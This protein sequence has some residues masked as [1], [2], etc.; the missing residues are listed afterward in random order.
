[1]PFA[2]EFPFVASSTASGTCRSRPAR[3]PDIS[4]KVLKYKASP[5]CHRQSF[6]NERTRKH[7]R[8]TGPRPIQVGT[9]L[10]KSEIAAI[11]LFGIEVKAERKHPIGVSWRKVIS[12]RA[13]EILPFCLVTANK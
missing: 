7:E 12:M 2:P 5:F 3:G 10:G 11:I 1:M 9:V 6:M 13:K 8:C 4:H